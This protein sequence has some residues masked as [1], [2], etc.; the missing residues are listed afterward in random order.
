MLFEAVIWLS[1]D[2]VFSSGSPFVRMVSLIFVIIVH[3]LIVMMCIPK[4]FPPK[5]PARDTQW[6]RRGKRCAQVPGV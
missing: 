4:W 5:V 3:V 1:I 6:K 2:S